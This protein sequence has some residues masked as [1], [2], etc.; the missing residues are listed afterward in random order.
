MSV[1]PIIRIDFDNL[2]AEKIELPC[3]CGA[4]LHAK[5]NRHA[6]VYAVPAAIDAPVIRQCTRV[7]CSNA[8][9]GRQCWEVVFTTA[10]G[11]GIKLY[12]FPTR[13][14]AEFVASTPGALVK[15]THLAKYC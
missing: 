1:T 14:I 7:A 11:A 10:D 9:N 3:N 15:H 2:R 4:C 8:G 13:A 6:S 12:E 5:A